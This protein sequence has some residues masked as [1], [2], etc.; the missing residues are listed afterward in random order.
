MEVA[1]EEKA[2]VYSDRHA[3]CAPLPALG[4]GAVVEVEIQQRVTPWAKSG[5]NH[6]F[7]LQNQWPTRA[8]RVHVTA[9]VARAFHV[10][11]TGAS[12]P[13]ELRQDGRSHLLAL[14]VHDLPAVEE[15]E[16]GSPEDLP[17]VP[18]LWVS[19]APDW[20][21]AAAEYADIVDQVLSGAH[22]EVLAR[23]VVGETRDAREAANRILT[24]MAP[25]RYA[26]VNLGDT[27]IVPRARPGGRGRC[28]RG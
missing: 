17:A 23:Q 9:P 3:V 27:S 21:H 22:L 15:D 19:T 26:S 1:P 14:E 12:W 24:W 20:Q 28:R 5:T 6:R 4:R 16:P 2:D 7:P 10:T 8:L 13:Y 18:L 11:E 25:L